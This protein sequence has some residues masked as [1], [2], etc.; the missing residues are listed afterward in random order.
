[1]QICCYDEVVHHRVRFGILTIAHETNRV[2]FCYLKTTM[3]LTGGNLSQCPVSSHEAHFCR[4]TT[5]LH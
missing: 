4:G 3:E 1:M 2:E 5:Q